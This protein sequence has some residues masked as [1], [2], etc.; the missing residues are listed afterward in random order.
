ML[1]GCPA[2]VNVPVRGEVVVFAA[3]EYLVVPL[4]VPFAP[5]V[6]AS[7]DVAVD[8]VHAHVGAEAVTPT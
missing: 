1:T 5:E 8:D 4:P 2:T 7:Q 3:T 6:M